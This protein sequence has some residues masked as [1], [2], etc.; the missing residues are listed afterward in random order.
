MVN[1][2][3]NLQD[4]SLIYFALADLTDLADLKKICLI[5]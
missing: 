4:I 5:C 2:F 3:I 1:A